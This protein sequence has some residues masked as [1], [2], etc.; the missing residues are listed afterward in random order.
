MKK[1]TAFLVLLLISLLLI[2][3]GAWE[4]GLQP[5]PSFGPKDTTTERVES[6]ELPLDTKDIILPI[7]A[8]ACKTKALGEL[9]NLFAAIGFFDIGIIPCTLPAVPGEEDMILAVLIDGDSDFKTGASYPEDAKIRVLY[10]VFSS[11]EKQESGAES[12]TV[13]TTDAESLEAEGNAEETFVYLT[14]SGSKYHSKADCS[15]MKAPI[16]VPLTQAETD[17]YTPCKR[18]H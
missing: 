4:R 16:C 14:E 2:S 7:G 10:G 9:V 12:S 18:C 5:D 13:E 8:D 15:G 17:G 3:C 6:T 11:D 1:N